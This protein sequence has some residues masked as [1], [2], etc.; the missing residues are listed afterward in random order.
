MKYDVTYPKDYIYQY[1]SYNLNEAQ[2]DFFKY[3]RAYSFLSELEKKY[4]K[5]DCAGLCS[6]PLFYLT[7]DLSA[8]RPKQTCLEASVMKFTEEGKRARDN[9]KLSGYLA[10]IGFLFSLPLVTNYI[11]KESL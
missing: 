4:W 6:V 7:K 3:D 5:E 11:N 2:L 9:S 8:G 10:V 1:K